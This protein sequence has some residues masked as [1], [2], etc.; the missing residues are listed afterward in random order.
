MSL[1]PNISGGQG[2]LKGGTSSAGLT[3]SFNQKIGNIK[4]GNSNKTEGI[5]QRYVIGGVALV[6]LLG[7]VYILAKN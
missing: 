7:V 2:G 6:V 4:F 3:A 5:D 1:I